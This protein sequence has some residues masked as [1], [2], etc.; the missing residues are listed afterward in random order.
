[1]HHAIIEF[2]WL[3]LLLTELVFGSKKPVVLFCDNMTA[4]KIA[5]NLVQHDRTKHIELD[6]NFIQDNIDCGTIKVPYNRSLDKLADLCLMASL[7]DRS[8]YH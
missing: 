6:R 7:V 5:N 1:M 2:S 3:K 8:I 4:T